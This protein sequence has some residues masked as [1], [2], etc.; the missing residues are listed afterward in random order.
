MGKR[1]ALAAAV[2]AALLPFLGCVSTKSQM[3]AYLFD[4]AAVGGDPGKSLKPIK[5][6]LVWPLENIAVGSKSKGIETRFTGIFIDTLKLRS[7]FDGV[8]ILEEDQAK[9][10]MARAGE[11]L[12]LKKKPKAPTDGALIVTKLGQLAGA[13]CILLGRIE[14]YDEEKIDKATDT[15]VSASFNLLDAREKAYAAIDSFTPVKR[16]WRMHVKLSSLE[17]P[18]AARKGLDDTFRKMLESS[19]DRMTA[20]LGQGAV[21]SE[22]ALARRVDEL[23]ATAEKNLAAGEFDKALASWNEVLKLQPDNKKAKKGIEEVEKSKREAQEREKA[24]A[25]KKQIDETRDKALEA[26]K[27]GDLEAALAEWKKVIELDK[28]NGQAA[29]KIAALEKQIAAR[30]QKEAEEAERKAAA[31]KKAR[32]EAEKKAK[33]EA[34]T[35]AREEAARKAEEAA[36]KAEEAAKKAAEP[37]AAPAVEAVP[38]AAALEPAAQQP[39]PAAEPK[40]E[41]SPAAEPESQPAP[42]VTPVPAA[43][44]VAPPAAQPKAV[45]APVAEPKVE[46]VAEKKAEE[47][48]AAAVPAGGGAL[49]AVRNQAMDAFNKED[50]Q[51]SK[52]LWKQILEKAPDDKQ[53]KEMLETTEMLLNA[54]K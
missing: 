51:A 14:D 38:G 40:A 16:V 12:G 22:K 45:T 47:K 41:A 25:L 7:G 39:A 54:L 10:L 4:D 44:P 27:G 19:V 3:N 49:D 32:E 53:A 28:K 24:A 48:P 6:V 50:Y 46:P 30:K 20:D 17:T 26:E 31:E 9:D 5:T 43:E 33:E 21:A 29:D 37:A 36:R 23:A 2:L 13:E 15:V 18:F 42:A 34:E 11:E 52:D 35:K 8:V 1:L